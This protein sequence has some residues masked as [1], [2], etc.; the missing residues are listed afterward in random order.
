LATFSL[1]LPKESDCD[2]RPLI[3][4]FIAPK[5]DIEKT[6]ECCVVVCSQSVCRD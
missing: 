1:I 3:A 4:L 6:P 5:I 2:A